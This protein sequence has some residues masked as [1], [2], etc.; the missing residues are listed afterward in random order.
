[1]RAQRPSQAP[2]VHGARLALAFCH[3]PRVP[4]TYAG[5][6]VP[7]KTHAPTLVGQHASPGNISPAR[8]TWHPWCLVCESRTVMAAAPSPPL[9]AASWKSDGAAPEL[10]CSALLGT[11]FE[12][13]LDGEVTSSAAAAVTSAVR[14]ASPRAAPCAP[15]LHALAP[16][17]CLDSA[18]PSNC[19]RHEHNA[20]DFAALRRKELTRRVVTAASQ[21][22]QT[23]RRARIG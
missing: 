9:F 16:W 4:R 2:G 7:R 15:Q 6:T 13:L 11:D 21:L 5:G 8:G 17:G 3:V 22:P 23:P 1:M 20:R 18:H 12:W 14:E 19:S 10:S